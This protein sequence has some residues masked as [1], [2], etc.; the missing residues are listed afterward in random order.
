MNILLVEPDKSLAH[1]YRRAFE[2]ASHSVAVAH[3]AQAAIFSADEVTPNVVVLELQLVAHSGLEFLYEFRSYPEWQTI[4]VVILSH[5][6]VGEFAGSWHML[7][8]LLGVAAYHYKP[9]TT[10][11]T[12]L[13][14]VSQ[15][16]TVNM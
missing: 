6:P 1:V 15:F 3:S 4:P 2:H 12:L 7:H 14:T 13:R 10:L 5:V 11:H 16:A 8:N 9:L